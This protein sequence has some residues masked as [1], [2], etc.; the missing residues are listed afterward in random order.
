MG[1]WPAKPPKGERCEGGVGWRTDSL[2][3]PVGIRCPNEAT[4]TCY[5][6]ARMRIETYLC[7]DHA[8]LAIRNPRLVRAADKEGED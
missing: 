2:G 5:A 3:K 6:S 8:P 7:A 1:R 4:E